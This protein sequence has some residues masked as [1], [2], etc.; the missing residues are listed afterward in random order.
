MNKSRMAVLT[1]VAAFAL[2]LVGGA[3]PAAAQTSTPLTQ[4]VKLTGTA[5]NGKTYKGTFAIQRFAQRDGKLSAIGTMR[6]RKNGRTIT[7][8][9]VAVPAELARQAQSSQIPPTT[10][11]CQILNLTLQPIEA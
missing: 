8:R 5:K 2:L 6:F 7:R 4:V 1:A 11:A 9:N 3:G 10:G